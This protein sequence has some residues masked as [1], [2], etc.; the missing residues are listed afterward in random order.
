MK[1]RLTAACVAL[2]F[3][4]ACSNDK[5]AGVD[6][7]SDAVTAISGPTP[8]LVPLPA[9]PFRGKRPHFYILSN[10]GSIA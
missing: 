9:N 4:A 6:L 1:A 7:P 8:K 3:T 10:S 5:V 2:L